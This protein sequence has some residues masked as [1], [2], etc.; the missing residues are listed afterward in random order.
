MGLDEGGAVDGVGFV[1]VLM[2]TE[3]SVGGKYSIKY[4]KWG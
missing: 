1:L 3:D 4:W 2:G